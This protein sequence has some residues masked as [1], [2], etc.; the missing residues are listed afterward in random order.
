MWTSAF[1]GWSSSICSLTPPS[2]AR[3]GCK[4][5][6][7][8]ALKEPFI[9]PTRDLLICADLSAAHAECQRHKHETATLQDMLALLRTVCSGKEG[10]ISRAQAEASDPVCL[11]TQRLN[12]NTY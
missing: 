3:S 2:V 8:N 10:E 12:C 11:G 4:K 1:L 5:E 9:F 6:P 7:C